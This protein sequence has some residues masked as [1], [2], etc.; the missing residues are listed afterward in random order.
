M[1]YVISNR[2]R[3]ITFGLMGVGLLAIIYG[4][5]TLKPFG[6]DHNATR[7][8]ANMFINS[9]FFMAISLAAT[10]FM[11]VQYI[12]QSGWYTAI[13][14]V[15][16]AIS[17]YIFVGALIFAI[18][19]ALGGHHLYH[20]Q[21]EG[22]MEKGNPHYDEIIAGKSGF[23]NLP[24]F[25]IA[26]I[27]YLGGWC[28]FTWVFRKRSIE[29]DTIGG[30]TNHMK[31]YFM[32]AWFV[33][34]FA[35]SSSTSAWHWILSIDT[36]WFSTM[37]G[38]Y[39]FAGMFISGLIT[40]V[41]FTVYLKSKGYL[42]HVNENHLH[43]IGK[44]MFAFSVFWTYI[45]FSQFMLIWYAN[46]PEEVT[47]FLARFESYKPLMLANIVI[48]F[49]FPFFMLMM[50]DAK[51]H[52]GILAFV[53]SIIFVG[54]WSDMFIIVMPGTVGE[55][56][57]YGIMEV[58]TFLFFLGLFLFIVHRSLAKAPTEVKN[59]PFLEESLHHHI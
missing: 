38:W 19:L 11:A 28:A 45:W 56:L 54:H 30:T 10:F 26:T 46:I 29:E 58:G 39:I 17:Q 14:R 16:E 51:R 21:H 6:D 34:F 25:W 24:F 40:I 41:L 49:I 8:W 20:W 2:T 22:I 32:A 13:K 59:H 42:P 50:R 27:I 47:Y 33:V 57:H 53:G 55:K 43:D 36:H 23:L 48:N 3:T 7:F 5:I 35:V 37:F 44:F 4:A 52:A 9:F 12:G 15:F 18:V 31:N 1:N